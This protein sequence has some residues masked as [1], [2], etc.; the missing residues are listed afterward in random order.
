MKKEVKL[1]DVPFYA[2]EVQDINVLAR[3]MSALAD[4]VE[5]SRHA[6][7]NARRHGIKMPAKQVGIQIP[8]EKARKIFNILY[9]M[10]FKTAEEVGL[11][12]EENQDDPDFFQE[13]CE[14]YQ[15][16]SVNE[17][18]E[19]IYHDLMTAII[20]GA[21]LNQLS[22]EIREGLNEEMFEEAS[23]M[24]RQPAPMQAVETADA[25]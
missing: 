17:N 16:F 8:V 10:G 19:I 22:E 24:H 18:G 3:I 6:E 2:P 25:E 11:K 7:R 21:H 12:K 20:N 13:E 15:G 14:E 4:A 23:S 5:V 9:Q 1:M